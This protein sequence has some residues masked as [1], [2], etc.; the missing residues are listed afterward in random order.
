M[1]SHLRQFW[2]AQR[3]EEAV[4][5]GDHSFKAP[6]SKNQNSDET[7]KQS[8]SCSRRFRRTMHDLMHQIVAEADGELRREG[9]ARVATA[10]LRAMPR[11]CDTC[12][13][14]PLETGHRGCE[15]CDGVTT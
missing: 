9:V 1:D 6:K 3:F 14:K 10:R 11:A 2:A 5:F 12:N 7:F 8:M 4:A 15:S 13:T